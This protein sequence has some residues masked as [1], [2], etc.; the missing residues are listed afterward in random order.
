MLKGLFAKAEKENYALREKVTILSTQSM[1]AKLVFGGLVTEDEL[2]ENAKDVLSEFLHDTMDLE[3]PSNQI[4]AAHRIRAYSRDARTPRLV[5]ATL[6]PAL[7]DLILS[8][9]RNLKGKK[10]TDG[11]AY[12]VNKHL[13]DQWMEEKRKLRADIYKAKKVN[14]EKI[15]NDQQPDSIEVKN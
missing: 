9:L 15:K 14:E 11:K 4:I 12:R 10:N 3:F 8:N 1:K 6:H 13:P 5:V 7:R 2:T